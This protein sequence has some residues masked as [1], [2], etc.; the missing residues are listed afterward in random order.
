MKLNATDAKRKERLK[1][2]R[3]AVINGPLIVLMKNLHGHNLHNLCVVINLSKGLLS[4]FVLD[5]RKGRVGLFFVF[6]DIYSNTASSPLTTLSSPLSPHVR[7][8][9]ICLFIICCL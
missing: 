4:L 6:F 3:G 9:W 1:T 7:T 2:K 8:L 5:E